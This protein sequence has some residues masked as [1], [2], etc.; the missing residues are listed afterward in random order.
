MLELQHSFTRLFSELRAMSYEAGLEI[1]RLWSLEERR[2]RLDLIEVYKMMHGFTDF[3]VSTF[4]QIAADGYQLTHHTVNS[5]PVNSTHTRLITKSTRHKRAHKKAIPVAIFYL[6][7]GQVAPINS[8]EHG[9][10][11][12]A[13]EY[14]QDIHNAVQFDLL[15]WV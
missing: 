15:I 6:Q 7:A 2:N 5:S 9:R 12:T 13:S 11:I 1:L 10:L 3:T 14:T 4:F 8:A